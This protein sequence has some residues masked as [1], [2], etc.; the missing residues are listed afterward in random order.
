MRYIVLGLSSLFLCTFV[1][2]LSLYPRIENETVAIYETETDEF[3]AQA[4]ILE[5]AV[6]AEPSD[7]V[8][9]S[10][11]AT[12]QQSRQIRS[13]LSRAA[14][15]VVLFSFGIGAA[16][17]AYKVISEFLTRY[18][19]QVTIQRDEAVEQLQQLERVLVEPRYT[20]RFERQTNLQ[21]VPPV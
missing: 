8:I 18:T 16:I 1:C 19:R 21:R 4:E 12:Q 7:T 10:Y 13:T 11:I 17:A 2:G 20:K 3:V 14:A 5:Q 6:S 9:Q 15:I